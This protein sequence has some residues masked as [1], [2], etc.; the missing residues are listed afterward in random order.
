MG[1]FSSTSIARLSSVFL[2]AALGFAALESRAGKIEF[3]VPAAEVEVPDLQKEIKAD[4]KSVSKAEV[5]F[6]GSLNVGPIGAPV[7]I[8][9]GQDSQRD[10]FSL[11]DEHKSLND[12]GDRVDRNNRN[13]IPSQ[14]DPANAKRNAMLS[15]QYKAAKSEDQVRTD[16]LSSSSWEASR[17]AFERE[18]DSTDSFRDRSVGWSTL[19]R[20]AQDERD[21]KEQT[22]RLNGFRALYETPNSLSPVGTPAPN[23]DPVKDSL[24]REPNLNSQ[25]GRS[26][27]FSRRDEPQ[28]DQQI[29]GTRGSA[30]ESFDQGPTRSSFEKSQLAPVREFDQ[31]R[32]V[33]EMPK[34]PGDLL[35]R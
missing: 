9:P 30:M 2:T 3:S 1:L 24:W 11:K 19:F 17:R 23:S 10:P 33:L 4:A 18:S 5:D 26:E 15:E 31:H 8:V 35:N 16:T 25:D 29:P 20:D 7:V 32:G 6:K 22:A 21:R 28:Y 12:R 27:L 14:D 13:Y 34:R